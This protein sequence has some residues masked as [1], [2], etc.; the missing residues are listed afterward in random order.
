MGSPGETAGPERRAVEL[1]AQEL[2]DE[3]R[4]AS[5]QLAKALRRAR[6]SHLQRRLARL[7]K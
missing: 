4:Q 6:H 3:Q 2:R 1:L 7:V 5:R